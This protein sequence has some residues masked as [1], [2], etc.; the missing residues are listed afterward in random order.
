MMTR[1][2]VALLATLP[3]CFLL[4]AGTPASAQWNNRDQGRRPN[5][6]DNRYDDGY[7]G[8]G[9]PGRGG[10]YG[11]EFAYRR[12]LDEGTQKGFEDLR[13]GRRYDV[14]RHKRYREGDNGYEREYGPREMFKAA[15]RDG[16][17]AGYDRA[18]R[19]GFRR[20]DRYR[21]RDDRGGRF[22]IGIRFGWPF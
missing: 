8:Y 5:G 13:K 12:G 4:T 6:Y 15:Y 18:F 21:D 17:R 1:T 14:L 10:G 9:G 3:V 19:D 7:R 22:G 20:D 2:R 16:F 11:L